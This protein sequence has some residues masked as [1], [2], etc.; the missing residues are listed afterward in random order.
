MEFQDGEVMPLSANVSAQAMY[1]QCDI[2]R[3]EYLVDVKC[4]HA[5]ITLEEQKSMHNGQLY[6]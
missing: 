6:S 5:A 4:D 3:N 1:T 2:D